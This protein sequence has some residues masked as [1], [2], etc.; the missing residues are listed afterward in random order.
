MGIAPCVDF[1]QAYGLKA[2]S[3]DLAD[4]HLCHKEVGTMVR[5]H[6]DKATWLQ[7]A[8]HHKSELAFAMLEGFGF[9]KPD[10]GGEASA[11]G[12]VAD[13]A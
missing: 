3:A 6:S 12:L 1:I 7:S 11:H 4:T 8:R 10:D 5:W 2:L 9:I 13:L